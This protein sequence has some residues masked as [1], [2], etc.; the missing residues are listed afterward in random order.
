M[1]NNTLANTVRIG[2]IGAWLTIFGILLSGPL[3]LFIVTAV[4]PSGPWQDAATY[5]QNYHPI[6]TLPFFCGFL[7]VGGYVVM[8]AALH[9]LAEER[10]KAQTLIAVVFTT[11]FATLIFFNYLNQTTFVPALAQN[12]IPEFDAAIS[13]F[14]LANPLSLCWAIEMW[15]YAFLGV[16]TWLAAPIFNRNR[17][18]RATAVL[19]IAN[20][21]VSIVGAVVTAWSLGWVLTVPGMISYAAWN[22]LVFALSILVVLSLRRRQK[23]ET[24]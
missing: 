18:E 17:L 8:M 12:Y 14:S 13:I 3:G 19:M 23:E 7:L 1:K 21:V 10:H 5:A 15:G 24:S 2:L 22:V 20:G 9:Q 6:Q 11:I 16:A 4:Q